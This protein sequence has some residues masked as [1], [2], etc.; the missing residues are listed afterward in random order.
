MKIKYIHA[1]KGSVIAL[2]IFLIAV[3]VIPGHGPSREVEIIV[4]ISTFL[5]AILAGFFIS[6]LNS[7]YDRIREYI[8]TEDALWLTLFQTS[9]LYG[10]EFNDKMREL[11]DKYYILAFDYS[12]YNEHWYKPTA[13]VFFNVYDLLNEYGKYRKEASYQVMLNHL[14]K[15]EQN[16]N[17]G[18]VLTAEKVTTGH[19]MILISLVVIIIYSV[20]YL[21]VPMFYSQVITV[22]LSTIL[23]LVLL[24]IRDLQNLRLGGKALIV[25]SGQEIFEFIGRLRYYNV[26]FLRNKTHE[27]PE[28]VK[29]YRVGIHKPG[30]KFEDFDIKIVKR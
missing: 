20:F 24:L 18:A 7:R 4:T 30:I 2:F 26:K 3:I 17:K 16:R 22:L 5:F 1:V 11:I 27:V 14:E 9:K 12:N 8:A 13:C 19:W 23:V 6:R 29:E 10:K 28:D 25:D 21:K 15:I